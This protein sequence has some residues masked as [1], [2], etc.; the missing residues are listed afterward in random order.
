MRSPLTVTVNKDLVLDAGTCEEVS[1][2]DGPG[3]LLRPPGTTLFHQVL[4]YLREKPDPVEELRGSTSDREG[5]AAAA[6]TLRWGSYLAVLLDS[7]KPVWSEVKSPA[8]SRISDEEMARINIEASA[9]VAEWVDLC[10]TDRNQRLYFKL[11][12]RAVSYLPM[13]KRKSKLRFSEFMALADPEIATK[14]I[15]ACDG[16]Y[17]ERVRAE[18]EHS[19]SR[20]FANTLTNHAWRNGPVEDIHAGNSRGYPLDQRRMSLQEERELMSFASERLA[21]GM[22]VCRQFS[23]EEPAHPWS[24]QVVPYGLAAILLVTP[25]RWTL[26]E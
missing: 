24:E 16:V 2:P 17:L 15:E 3:L 11:V 10:R 6:V 22:Q 8:T 7:A 26:T 5:I 19:A 13:T 23:A 14:L 25:S 12:D 1:G 20:L 9:A 4:A 21:L 18:A